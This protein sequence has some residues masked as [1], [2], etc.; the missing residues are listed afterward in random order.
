MHFYISDLHLGDDRIFALCRRPFSSLE[1]ME[2]NIVE[3][4]NGKVTDNDDVYI[5][6]DLGNGSA[7]IITR[8]FFKVKGRKH[9]IVGNHDEAFLREYSMTG[10]FDS[11]EH[12]AYINDN[13]RKVCLCHYP[14][15]DWFSGHETIYQ[16]YGHIHNKTEENG[17]MYADIR[18][19]YT[20][21]LAFNASVDVIGFEPVTLDE[22]IKFKEGRK[23]DPYI[24]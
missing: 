1:D 15:M 17:K 10:L 22:L 16:V 5:L 2:T 7:D 23:H 21:K 4:W 12:I 20:D 14:L 6:G 19:Y 9:L 8:F 11:I 3:K 18:H 24:H 13:G